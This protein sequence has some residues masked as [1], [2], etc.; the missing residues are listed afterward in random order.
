VSEKVYLGKIAK[1][2]LEDMYSVSSW[3][4]TEATFLEIS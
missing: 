1:T 4:D 2:A 3:A